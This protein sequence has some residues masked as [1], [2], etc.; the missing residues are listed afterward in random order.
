MATNVAKKNYMV[1]A[2]IKLEVGLPVIANSFAEAE[3]AGKKLNVTDFV[4]VLGD[5]ADNDDPEI[6]W[7]SLK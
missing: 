1:Y 3:E 2:T 4:K 7:I 5:F 6:A